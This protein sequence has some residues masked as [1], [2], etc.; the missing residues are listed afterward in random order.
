L[1]NLTAKDFFYGCLNETIRKE[2]FEIL[3]NRHICATK[4]CALS[5]ALQYNFSKLYEIGNKDVTTE[6]NMVD[7]NAILND[8]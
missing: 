5:Q 3:K 2:D 7:I 1:H 8:K 4:L 6:K